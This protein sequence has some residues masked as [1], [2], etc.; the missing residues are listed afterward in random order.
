MKNRF[1]LF[2]MVLLWIPMIGSFAQDRLPVREFIQ[3]DELVVLQETLP[4]KEALEVLEELSTRFKDKIIIDRSGYTG[5]INVFIPGMHWHDALKRIVAQHQL[6]LTEYPRFF[7]INRITDT[8]DP[9]AHPA[10]QKIIDFETREIEIKATFFEGNRQLIRELGIDWSSLRNGRVAVTNIAAARV[11]DEALSVA[12]NWDDV[13]N[14]GWDISALFNAFESSNKGE[15]LSSPTIKVIESET[16]RIQ[17]GQDFS[18]KQK[19]FAGNI[20]DEFFSTGTILQVTPRVLYHQSNPFIYMTIT[21]ERSTAL[22]GAI[23]TIVNKQSA[24]TEI[25]LLNGESTIIAGLYETDE[26]VVRRGVPLLK[27]LP[28]WFFGLRYLFGYNSKNYT[29]KELVVIIQA[30]L[31][32]TLEERLNQSLQT[33]PEIMNG[34]IDEFREKKP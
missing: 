22:P 34:V 5:P 9:R 18:I 30:T 31:L 32:P 14:S 3:P 29:T 21:A 13:L 19:D 20:I 15:V 12:V 7:E 8:V 6:I 10:I 26:N 16:G 17:V 4:F 1:T 28:G 11:S 27:D 33:M 2:V 25:L 24:N 23:S